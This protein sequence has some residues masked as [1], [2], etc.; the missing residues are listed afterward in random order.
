M[1]ESSKLAINGG[2]KSVTN[3]I[4]PW[5]VA[6]D[7]VRQSLQSVVNSNAW[8]LYDG[9]ST[10]SLQVKLQD[11][12]DCAHSLLSCS[13]TMAVEL[14]LRGVGV[15]HGDEVILAAYDF[16]GNFRA[17]EAIGAMPV[18]VDVVEDAWIIET[19]TLAAAVSE[20]TSAVLVS[21][22]HGQLIDFAALRDSLPRSIP[23]VE[24]CCQVPGA[25]IDG[26]PCGSFGDVSAFSFGGSKLLSA[27]RGGAVL[28][29]DESVI[30]RAKHFGSR[31]NDAFPL[32]QLQAAVLIPQLDELESRNLIRQSAVE[33]MVAAV[34]GVCG[35]MLI[36]PKTQ[37]T[38]AWYKLPWRLRS[39]VDR[40]VVVSRLKAE[41][42]PVDVGFRG[43]TKRTARRCRKV[44]DLI[45]AQRAAD[46]TILLHHPALLEPA[47][48]RKQIVSGFQ[49]VMDS[50]DG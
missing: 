17:I 33:E 2:T 32:S 30:S 48:T 5:P 6:S 3:L 39:N 19:E 41:G 35:S 27:G 34:E 13:G 12:F 43:F 21:H 11:V 38:S 47:D 24:D 29:D 44:G 14:A 26:K 50:L 15:K 40:E 8:G 36:R 4:S 37:E 31:G 18:L 49:K 23:V 9:D 42:V 22:L 46:E 7:A 45:N 1:T 16:P 25:S 20:K 28:S 10:D